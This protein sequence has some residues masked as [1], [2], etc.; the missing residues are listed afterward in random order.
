[1]AVSNRFWL[2]VIIDDHTFDFFFYYNGFECI[3]SIV[4]FNNIRIDDLEKVC[5]VRCFS[6]VL[7]GMFQYRC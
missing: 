5:T 3:F 7:N 6:M 2:L 4:I 1:M